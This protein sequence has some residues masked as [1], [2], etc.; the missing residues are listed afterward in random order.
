M[1]AACRAI[2]SYM[3]TK[4]ITDLDANKQEVLTD[5]LTDLR[6]Y[7]GQ[8]GIDWDKIDGMVKKH[9]EAEAKEERRKFTIKDQRQ[10][11]RNGGTRCPN[12]DSTNIEAD[13]FD[14]EMEGRKITCCSCDHTWTE[15]WQITGF[16]FLEDKDGYSYPE[17]TTV[18][19]I[20]LNGMVKRLFGA[21]V[22]AHGYAESVKTYGG[23]NAREE[24][25]NAI[26]EARCYLRD[27]MGFD[28]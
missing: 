5:L 8:V 21:L 3:A 25:A 6:H 7:A 27:A 13:A 12:C 4:W 19:A 20:D 10:Y 24:A 28:V 16:M 1:N 17:T 9:Y 14:A 23:S 26:E 11:L 15:C 18:Q 2:G 22:E